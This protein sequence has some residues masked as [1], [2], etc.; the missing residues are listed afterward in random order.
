[1]KK[2]CIKHL[3]VANPSDTSINTAINGMGAKQP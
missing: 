1:M 2:H 3:T